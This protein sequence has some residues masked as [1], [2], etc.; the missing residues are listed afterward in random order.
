MRID[1]LPEHIHL[2]AISG[3][4][5]L[6]NKP[7]KEFG[8]PAIQ[9]APIFARRYRRAKIIG[10]VQNLQELI[11][12]V[13]LEN[14]GLNQALDVTRGPWISQLPIF[15]RYLAQN[16]TAKVSLV[17]RERKSIP[18]PSA[19]ERAKNGDYNRSH[20]VS[21][22]ISQRDESRV[23]ERLFAAFQKS[24]GLSDCV[25]LFYIILP[26]IS[27]KSQSALINDTEKQLPKTIVRKIPRDR[28]TWNTYSVSP[29]IKSSASGK[30]N[31]PVKK[32]HWSQSNRNF[33]VTSHTTEIV[34]LLFII[35]LQ[36]K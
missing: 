25:F 33:H 32:E 16:R 17:L 36:N 11:V 24:R 35:F 22:Y 14:T 3:V 8:E 23:L 21:P 6:L 15:K 34:I 31:H 10:Q 26:A 27:R 12:A 4:F 9:W 20:N 2:L 28:E 29:Y 19:K 13:A 30:T 5:V 18:Q 7:R 1:L